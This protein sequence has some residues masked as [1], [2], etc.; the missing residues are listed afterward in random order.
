M[1]KKLW[2][3]VCYFC[4]MKEENGKSLSRL[5]YKLKYGL[6]NLTRP[7]RTELQSPE[8]IVRG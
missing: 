6:R 1:I 5:T 7:R 3:L 4:I 8:H 2:S